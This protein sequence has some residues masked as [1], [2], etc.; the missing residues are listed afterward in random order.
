VGGLQGMVRWLVHVLPFVVGVSICSLEPP[1][2]IKSAGAKGCKGWPGSRTRSAAVG[3]NR[4]G[5][6]QGEAEPLQP[7]AAALCVEKRRAR[8]QV[9]NPRNWNKPA[10]FPAPKSH[11]AGPLRTGAFSPRR[12]ALQASMS[13]THRRRGLVPCGCGAPPQREPRPSRAWFT[14]EPALRPAPNVNPWSTS[15]FRLP[16]PTMPG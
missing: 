4:T 12:G 3:E 14:S 11:C 8:E 7:V 2:R 6:D 9:V 5:E 15:P 16:E 13:R 10:R 1:R